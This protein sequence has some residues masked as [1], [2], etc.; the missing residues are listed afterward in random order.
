MFTKKIDER[1]GLRPLRPSIFRVFKGLFLLQL[2]T[3]EGFQDADDRRVVQLAHLHLEHGAIELG[4]QGC[5]GQG[6]A[7]LA[8]RIQDD[9]QVLRLHVRLEARAGGCRQTGAA[10]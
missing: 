3:G 10:A 7:V 2:N 1:R 5:G 8:R 6:D 4:I 9:V